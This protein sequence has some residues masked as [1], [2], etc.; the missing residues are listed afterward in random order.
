M[1]KYTDETTD[2]LRE[3]ASSQTFE[4]DDETKVSYQEQVLDVL[5]QCGNRGVTRL[6]APPH[7]AFSLPARISELRKRDYKI[8]TRLTQADSPF[9]RYFL[10]GEPH[11]E[12]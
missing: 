5:R 8:L 9:G 1:V 6:E 2:A 3:S 4:P 11:D 12:N 10:L 7:L